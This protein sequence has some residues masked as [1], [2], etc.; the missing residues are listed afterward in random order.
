MS[1]SKEVASGTQCGRTR[2]GGTDGAMSVFDLREGARV[3]SYYLAGDTLNG[4]HFHPFLPL[5]ATASGET[6][7]VIVQ[8][9][10]GLRQ[11]KCTLIRE[12]G[13]YPV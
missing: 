4:V 8:H 11:H 12:L 3:A 13:V 1:V 9:W 5:L 10:L 6:A 7:P 2:A